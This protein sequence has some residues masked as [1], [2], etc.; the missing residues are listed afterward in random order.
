LGCHTQRFQQKV[1]AQNRT[2]DSPLPKV[3]GQLTPMIPQ[4]RRHC[5]SKTVKTLGALSSHCWCHLN[6]LL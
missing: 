1:G 5:R 6:S 4:D 3:G 2:A